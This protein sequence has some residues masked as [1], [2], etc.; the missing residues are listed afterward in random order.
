MGLVLR[1]TP[2]GLPYWEDDGVPENV[3][4]PPKVSEVAPWILPDIAGT[5]GESAPL[6]EAPQVYPRSYE[7]V[8]AQRADEQRASLEQRRQ[9]QQPQPLPDVIGPATEPLRQY[10]AG[11]TG[12]TAA[13]PWNVGALLLEGMKEPAVQQLFPPAGAVN[14]LPEGA[15][16]WMRS[17]GKGASDFMDRMF[18]AKTEQLNPLERLARIGGESTALGGPAPKLATG[19]T[20]G[21][22]AGWE[23]LFGTTPAEAAPG[24][25]NVDTVGGPTQVRHSE[26][27]TLG[28]L[29]AATLGMAFAP[30]I[31]AN[32]KMGRVPA[33]RSVREAAP[34]TMD[35]TQSH[36]LLATYADVNAGATQAMRRV[37]RRNGM[38]PKALSD[39]EATMQMQTRATAHALADGAVSAGRMETPAFTF[40]SRV[41]LAT[42]SPMES[43]PVSDYLHVMHT[44]D[45]IKKESIRQLNR[46]IQAGPITIRGL[47]L[48]QATAIKKAL[49]QSNPEVVEISKAY[50]ENLKSLRKFETTGEYGTLSTSKVRHLNKDESNTVPW[51]GPVTTG[52][53]IERGSAIA[54]LATYMHRHIVSRLQNEAVGLYVD[55]MKRVEP[56]MFRRVTSEELQANQHW[57]KNTVTFKRRGIEE[58]YTTSPLI[59]DV[60][61]MDPYYMHSVPGQMAHTLKRIY[62]VTTTGE[63]AP[64]FAPIS[65]TRN[66]FLGKISAPGKTKSPTMLGTAYA[67]PQQLVPQLA[68]V[69]SKSL[70]KST[71]GWLS[72][73]FPQNFADAL[74]LRMADAYTRSLYHQLQ[75]VGGG[76][77][78]I[79]QQQTVAT[80]KFMTAVHNITSPVG[81]P[82]KAFVEGYHALLNAVHNAPSFNWA[83]RN[84]GKM[85][86]TKLAQ[87]ARGLTGD[88]RLG[89]QYLTRGEG[90]GKKAV[91][92]R[93]V[94]EESRV[95]HTMG[96]L[97]RG[98][99]GPLSE[100]ARTTVPW[101]NTTLQG[102][103]RLSR[104]YLEDPVKFTTRLWLYHM[105]PAAAGYTWNR[106][107]GT[108]P[109]GMDYS[110]YQM[111]RR[112]DYNK[113]MSFYMG[114]PGK[115]AE[116]GVEIPRVHEPSI[117][118]HLMEIA[119][120][121][122]FRSSIHTES[123]DFLRAAKSF[124]GVVADPPWPTAWGLA[125]AH[126]GMAVPMGMF[127]GEAYTKKVDP[128]DQSAGL[129]HSVELYA[130]SIG[131][132]IADVLGQGYSAFANTPDGIARSI[133]NGLKAVGRRGVEKTPYLRDVL[134]MHAPMTGNN[135]ITE[136]LFQKQ[137]AIRQLESYYREWD[138]GEGLIG[139]KPRSKGGEV[140]AA[141]KLGERPP[142]ESAGINQPAPTNP[143]YLML[144][145][146]VHN[147]FIKD[148]PFTAGKNPTETGAI[149]FQSLW[150]RYGI[151]TRQLNRIKK[152]N[153]GNNVTWQE[154]LKQRPEQ[155]AYLKRN[156]VDPTNI[157]EVRNF[158][159]RQR[160]DVARTI[161]YTIKSVEKD[162]SERIGQPIKIEDIN[163]Y[164]KGLSPGGGNTPEVEIGDVML[165]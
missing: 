94:N 68:G 37:L 151:A 163:P 8:I 149:G 121:H 35:I 102:I 85:P 125:L 95:S 24:M 136:E 160:Q 12:S 148:A 62:E 46:R 159:E 47:D 98:T 63:F 78:S 51:N 142:S 59:A 81:T 120:D 70:D 131:P 139:S 11:I 107:I 3:V 9:E 161:L 31:F 118:A 16:D 22:R 147:K 110:D 43:K 111:N 20:T 30:Q 150:N 64:W 100:G 7:D 92:I 13:M 48:Q 87:E 88:P 129:P 25:V 116:E 164:G 36:D 91:P 86:L 83:S 67:I 119:L 146:E 97:L 82:F 10:G 39:V 23:G 155:L 123:E 135:A 124:V 52:E 132:G 57:K 27:Y 144:M 56:G 122:A 26:L 41:P 38:D 76:R 42:L 73:V 138:K 153:E 75:T 143:L 45:D 115:P 66:Y 69:I 21:V 99:I 106:A 72:H 18:G 130:R 117:A 2:D 60:L 145:Q 40:Q 103:L 140:L 137:K 114:V 108:D 61:R 96:Q 28:G 65:M 104:A 158:Y 112:T 93:F 53:A 5:S 126:A 44:I 49:E 113:L 58:H 54:S 162:F 154:E 1:Y 89:G 71:G 165:Q 14:A 6:P 79:L 32:F 4:L 50:K 152:V 17:Q 109:N 133:Q 74:S 105:L 128:F 127:G 84:Y 29:A 34:G 141:G 90:V 134:N 80:N 101:F 156:N 19:I 15:T 33:L 157:R 55:S 77:G